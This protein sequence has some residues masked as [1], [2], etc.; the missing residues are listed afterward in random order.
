MNS[1]YNSSY[2]VAS[3]WHEL[4]DNHGIH[5]DHKEHKRC[6]E[7]QVAIKGCQVIQEAR[8]PI[9]FTVMMSF[10]G[11]GRRRRRSSSSRRG[12]QRQTET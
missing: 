5:A 10:T 11:G 7:E 12:L 3:E 1:D 6:H 4:A 2:L 8:N 9:Q